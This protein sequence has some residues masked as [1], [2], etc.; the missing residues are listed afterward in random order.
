MLKY[1]LAQLIAQAIQQA[2]AAGALPAVAVPPVDVEHPREAARGDDA[3][4][5]AMKLAK[6]AR[7]APLKIAQAIAAHLP[8][9]GMIGAA[10]VAAPGFINI[11]LS[12][13]FLGQLYSP[14]WRSDKGR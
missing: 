5:V 12:E 7:L 1:D 14:P 4:S 13:A 8:K 6:D 9:D 10:E 3:T 11:R 2:Q